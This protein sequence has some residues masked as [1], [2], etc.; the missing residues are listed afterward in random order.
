MIPVTAPYVRQ[1]DEYQRPAG[2]KRVLSWEQARS[3]TRDDERSLDEVECF[4]MGLRG[5]QL[6]GASSLR[7][8]YGVTH[9]IWGELV[10]EPLNPHDPTALAVDVDGVRV[11][12][13][14]A[15]AAEH[16][17]WRVRELNS[18]GLAVEVPVRLTIYAGDVSAMAALP[19]F[20]TWDEH[21][22]EDHVE[23]ARRLAPVW[24]HLSEGVR[25]QIIEDGFHLQPCTLEAFVSAAD[26]LGIT[27]VGF[28]K[29]P[30]PEALPRSVGL[31]LTSIRHRHR[32]EQRK[33]QQERD[34]RVI[35]LLATGMT[36]RAAADALGLSPSIVSSAVQRHNKAR[37]AALSAARK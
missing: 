8:D 25:A 34:A 30:V 19:T 11:G 27:G 28:P 10:P 21:L 9:E 12:Y 14:S 2:S 15:R 7:Y 4:W 26:D 37:T 3:V 20:K 33:K 17:H 24:S 18:R 32:E 5:S 35:E 23:Q 36:H 16:M 13:V 22:L 1:P 31:L 29:R 6:N